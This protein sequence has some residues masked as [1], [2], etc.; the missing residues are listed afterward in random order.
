VGAGAGAGA[1]DG[2]NR[3]ESS[4]GG[5]GGNS[6][7]AEDAARMGDEEKTIPLLGSGEDDSPDLNFVSPSPLFDTAPDQTPSNR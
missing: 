7:N 2:V 4:S 1:E 6:G 3:G 5:S